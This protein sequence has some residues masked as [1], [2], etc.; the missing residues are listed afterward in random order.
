MV[1]S[2]VSLFKLSAALF[3]ISLIACL[4]SI[5]IDSSSPPILHRQLWS[6]LSTAATAGDRRGGDSWLMKPLQSLRVQE[7][8]EIYE[9][10]G[11][12]T[13]SSSVSSELLFD[14]SEPVAQLGIG[15]IRPRGE[16]EEAEDGGEERI[17]GHRRTENGF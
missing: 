8:Y 2:S 9:I 1:F 14:L 13:G 12:R 7:I 10:S 4:P 5:F 15:L 11:D 6:A 17:D 3:T 16:K